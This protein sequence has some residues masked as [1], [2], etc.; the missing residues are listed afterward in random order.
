MENVNV[1]MEK[2]E[3]YSAQYEAEQMA[4]A[5]AYEEAPVLDCIPEDEYIPTQEEVNDAI[6]YDLRDN[7]QFMTEAQKSYLKTLVDEM[8][9]ATTPKERLYIE[10]NDLLEKINKLD[11]FMRKRDEN[12][13][14]LINKMG[15]TE[16]AVHLMG[17]Q[18]ELEKELNDVLVA[19]YSI[20]DVK[21][22]E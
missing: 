22:G 12:G 8:M 3:M 11:E 15:L 5:A 1:E 10:I 13:I 2:N 18:L 16:A 14:R 20:F 21:K 9:A 17:K 4:M 6:L 7:I 19:R